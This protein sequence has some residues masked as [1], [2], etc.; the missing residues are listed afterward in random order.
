[1]I[2]YDRRK[3]VIFN[4]VIFELEWECLV[5]SKHHGIQSTNTIAPKRKHLLGLIIGSRKYILFNYPL[6]NLQQI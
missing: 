1:M 2:I 3:P 5:F 6:N 4:Q